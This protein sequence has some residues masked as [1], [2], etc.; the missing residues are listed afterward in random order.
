[1]RKEL[2]L[3]RLNDAERLVEEIV[4]LTTFTSDDLKDKS[5]GDA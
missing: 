4:G 3:I 2:E 5:R 1:M